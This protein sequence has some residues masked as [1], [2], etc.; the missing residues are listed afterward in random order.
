MMFRAIKFLIALPVLVAAAL[1]VFYFLPAHTKEWTFTKLTGL[2]PEKLET[3]AR[4]L[5]LTPP[6]ERAKLIQEL[7]TRFTKLTDDIPPAASH[8]LEE[9]KALLQKLKAKSSESSLTELL[10]TKLAEKAVNAVFGT[11]TQCV[12]QGQ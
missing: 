7:E 3:K 11:T 9:S 10:K 8:V 2:V 4:E 6:E 1:V 12:P 5:L